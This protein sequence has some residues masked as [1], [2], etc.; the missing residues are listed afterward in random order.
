M[1]QFSEL[2]VHELELRFVL[3]FSKLIK[4]IIKKYIENKRMKHNI[5][6]QFSQKVLIVEV[7]LK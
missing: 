3:R 5:K 1:V 2:Q 7:K 6:T 4:N